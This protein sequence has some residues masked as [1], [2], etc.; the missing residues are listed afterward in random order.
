MY[1]V[2]TRSFIAWSCRKHFGYSH[3]SEEYH[4]IQAMLPPTNVKQV[5]Q[6]L[7]ICNYYR[8]FILDFAKISQ[9]IAELVKKELPFNWSVDCDAAVLKLKSM[10]LRFPI[11][12]QPD[13]S[14]PFY[15]Y[16]DASGYVLGAIL[17]RFDDESNEYVCQ[18]ASRLLKAPKS[19]MASQKKNVWPLFGQ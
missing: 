8:K 6:F 12:R 11:L 13:H 16:T 15:I 10:L 14:K 18:Y 4:A 3:G 17:P 1:M 19:I 5:H 7:G 9:Q 2:F